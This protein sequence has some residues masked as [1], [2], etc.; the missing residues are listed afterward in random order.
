M[1][2][3]V[4]QQTIRY[5][6]FDDAKYERVERKIRC[7]GK[8]DITR[9]FAKPL[10]NGQADLC[11]GCFFSRYLQVWLVAFAKTFPFTWLAIL[12]VR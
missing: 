10:Q 7:L 1:Y 6:P 8:T 3:A 5:N 2:R 12:S 9:L 11:G 4:S